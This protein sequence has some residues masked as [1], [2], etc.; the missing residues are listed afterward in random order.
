MDFGPMARLG[1]LFIR[2]FCYTVLVRNGLMR[3]VL[4]EVD[5][6]P[7]GLLAYTDRSITFH[8]YAMRNHWI[9]VSYI[10]LLSV[11]KDPRVLIHLVRAFRVI[12]SRRG[13]SGLVGEDPLA[14]VIALAVKP[15][16]RT[17]RFVREAG[18]KIS[19]ELIE[20]AASRFREA[21]FDR[22]RMI[23]DVDNKP[24]LMFYHGL[25][26]KFEPYEQGG[27]PSIHAWLDLRKHTNHE[28]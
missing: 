20:Y 24:T 1:E 8:R 26:A 22:M 3:A 17:A 18:R 5:G 6:N 27:K 7:A 11:L 23:V 19:E 28:A 25:G 13:E 10:L 9:N 16:Y 2:K 12:L 4:Y 21:G 14:E 15:E